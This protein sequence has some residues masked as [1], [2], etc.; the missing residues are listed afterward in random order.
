MSGKII[1]YGCGG[2]ARSIVSA[3]REKESETEIILVDE[4]A[5]QDER[6]MGCEVRSTYGLQEEDTYIVAIGDNAKRKRLA[7]NLK[8]QRCG[9]VRN[10]ISQ[11]AL[12][13]PDAV[14]G[15]GVFIAANAYVGPQAVIGRN[16]IIN[17]SSVIEH[18]VLIGAHTHIAPNA[19]ICGRAQVGNEVFCGVGSTIIDNVKVCDKVIIGAGAVVTEDITKSGIYVGVPAR[20]ISD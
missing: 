11:Y 4:N 13:R 1:L 20:R 12:V 16:T 3:I 5:G 6:I 8:Q 19:T 15:E 18:E 9:E 2:H 10:V 17:T 14:I 7:E